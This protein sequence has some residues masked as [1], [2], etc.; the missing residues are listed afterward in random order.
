[1]DIKLENISIIGD[2]LK[3]YDMPQYSSLKPNIKE[4]LYK[5]ET[6]IQSIIQ[7]RKASIEIYRSNKIN[8][9]N[10][11]SKVGIAR[12]TVYNNREVLETYILKNQDESEKNDVFKS[13]DGLNEKINSLNGI[14][15]K[16]QNKDLDAQVCLDRIEV[17]EVSNNSLVSEVG[18]LNEQ[19][20][21]F[22]I[23]IKK[24]HKELRKYETNLSEKKILLL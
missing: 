16:Q 17:L 11:V 4:Y 9:L 13:I 14:I 3:K 22:I 23:T 7:E 19:N 1:M 2:K 6:G 24:L 12:Q 15:L 18:K 5:I 20:A 21:Q 10:I 8:V